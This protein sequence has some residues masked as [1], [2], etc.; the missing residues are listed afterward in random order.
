MSQ[1][2]SHPRRLL[3][4]FAV[5]GLAALGL[6]TTLGGCGDEE[7]ASIAF[8]PSCPLTHIP[9]E[10]ADYYLYDG[11]TAT[12]PHLITRASILK[13]QGDCLGAGPKD[14]KTRIALRFVVNHGPA[15]AGSTVTLPWF[16]AV[17]HGDRIV[18]K[19]VF[20]H[21]FQF[22]ANLSSITSDSKVVTVDLPIPPKNIDSDYRFEVGFQLTKEQLDYNEKHLKKVDYQAY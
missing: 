18:N 4:R 11:K 22:P 10:A 12:F 13:L 15:A 1:D 9:P 2:L 7:N 19:H 8:A 5:S 14:L 21:T 20:K 17:L 6:L 16:I 3:P